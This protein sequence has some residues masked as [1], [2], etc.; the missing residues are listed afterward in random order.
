[1]AIYTT[2]DAVKTYLR[3]TTTNDDALLAELGGRASALVEDHC[4]RRFD[5]WVE[6]RT[7]DAAGPHITGHTLLLDADLLSLDAL[8]N[9]D[10]TPIDPAAVLLRPVNWPPYFGI[11]LRETSGLH[12]AAGDDPAGAI[13]VSGT[14]GYSQTVPEGTEHAAV[15]LAAWLYRQRDTAADTALLPRDVREMLVP[16]I[17]LRI[18]AF[19]GH[20]AEGTA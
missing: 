6:T 10:G 20:P 5:T 14:W 11:S 13:H 9:A 19:C 15:R 3:I 7:Y 8:T 4:G 1:M 18:K 2:V 17:R 16:F 12:W